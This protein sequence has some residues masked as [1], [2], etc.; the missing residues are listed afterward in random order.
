[1]ERAITGAEDRG[2]L[3]VHDLDDLLTGVE[4]LEHLLADGTLAHSG[5]EVLDD[6]EV[7]V[8]LE[9]R[10]AHLAQ[11]GIDVRL[12]NAAAAT[13]AAEDAAQSFGKIVKHGNQ[14][15]TRADGRP[16]TNGHCPTLP[17]R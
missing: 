12:G 8:R 13:Q 6:A 10:Q 17:R 16:R 1:M 9:Q 5:D 15:F 7:D 2:Q 14:E 3:L 11:G 4:A